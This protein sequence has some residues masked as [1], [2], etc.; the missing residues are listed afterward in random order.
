[1]HKMKMTELIYNYVV[2]NYVGDAIPFNPPILAS[3]GHPMVI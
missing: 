1:M 2:Y 3:L